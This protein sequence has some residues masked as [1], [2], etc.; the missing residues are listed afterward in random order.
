MVGAIITI[1]SS[2]GQPS[3]GNYAVSTADASETSAVAPSVTI[4]KTG[5]WVV[6]VA[7]NMYGTTWAKPDGSP[8]FTERVDARVDTGDTDV[9]L[10]IATAEFTSTGASSDKTFTSADADYWKAAQIEV[11]RP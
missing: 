4:Q 6:G 9:S 7:S 11:Q 1:R 5:N 2:S 8:T 10:T 3:I